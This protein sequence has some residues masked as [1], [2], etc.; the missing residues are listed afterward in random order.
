MNK[1]YQYLLPDRPA[2]ACDGQGVLTS[3][4]YIV[5]VTMVAV[6]PSNRTAFTTPNAD[7][8]LARRT[9]IS[10]PPFAQE[11]ASTSRG[12]RQHGRQQGRRQGAG[13]GSAG[14]YRPH[15][16]GGR[17]RL[18]GDRRRS[19]YLPDLTK[20]DD[21]NAAYREAFGG[22]DFPARARSAPG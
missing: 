20:F 22:K 19:V 12:C 14:A 21:M 16:E 3:A 5:E 6:K 10:A 17:L 9:R 7:G 4:D 18:V 13:R 15:A 1:V 2:G 11:I 8:R